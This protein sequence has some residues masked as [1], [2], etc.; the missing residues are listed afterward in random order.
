MSFV[1]PTVKRVIAFFDGQSLFHAAKSA[2]GYSHPNYDPKRLAEE[3]CRSKG[4][5]LVE[6]RFYTGMPEPT[7]DPEWNSYWARKLLTMNIQGVWTFS[8]PLRYRHSETI[9]PDGSKVQIRLPEEKGI[10]VRIAID[11]LR[12]CLKESY[13]VALIFSQDQDLSELAVEFRTISKEQDRWI[14][15]ASAFPSSPLY[16]NTRGINGTDWIPIEKPFYLS[17][18][19]I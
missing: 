12:L 13:D 15:I 4:W 19:H 18:I 11:I 8:R 14:K 1:E 16:R 5:L 7:D 2:F 6:T 17:L 10:D 3:I 9:L